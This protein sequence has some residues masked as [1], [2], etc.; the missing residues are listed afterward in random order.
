[1]ILTSIA[2]VIFFGE[3]N[4]RM[5]QNGGC[6]LS[7]QTKFSLLGRYCLV[8]SGPIPDS[9]PVGARYDSN[10]CK[11][12]DYRRRVKEKHSMYTRID[13]DTIMMPVKESRL[14]TALYSACEGNTL[15]YLYF[16]ANRHWY[17]CHDCLQ[18]TRRRIQIGT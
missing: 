10:A 8:C 7:E 9:K 14:V 15:V 13:A 1:M 6:I 17:I 16:Q 3:M 12:K 11:Q 5:I 2:L 18:V 4:V